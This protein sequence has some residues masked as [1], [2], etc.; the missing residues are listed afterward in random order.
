MIKLSEKEIDTLNK[1]GI[2]PLKEQGFIVDESF[3]NRKTEKVASH[4]TKSS[5]KWGVSED[6]DSGGDSEKTAWHVIDCGFGCV[7]DVKDGTIKGDTN[8]LAEKIAAHRQMFIQKHA[9]EFVGG[10]ND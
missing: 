6:S 3:F 10:N 7:I 4:L 1:L 8:Q 2:N 9:K 5:V